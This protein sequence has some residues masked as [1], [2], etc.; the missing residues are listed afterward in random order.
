MFTWL[1]KAFSEGS[2]DFDP[3]SARALSAICTLA[4]ISWVWYMLIHT[5][6]W[7][8]AVTFAGITTFSTI[9]YATN[10]LTAGIGK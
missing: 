8:D 5:H 9:H 2:P 10:K 1:A 3:S 4:S 6:L 7:P